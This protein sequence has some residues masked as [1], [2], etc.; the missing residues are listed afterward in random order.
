MKKEEAFQTELERFTL[1]PLKDKVVPNLKDHSND[2]YLVKKVNKATETIK[3][4]GIPPELQK[5]QAGHLKK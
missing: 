2:P 1:D 5:L 3:R 4:V